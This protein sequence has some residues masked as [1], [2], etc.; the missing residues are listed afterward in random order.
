MQKVTVEANFRVGEEGG[1]G[2][3]GRGRG[4]RG[5]RGGR[6]EGKPMLSAC[7][8]LPAVTP[9]VHQT[10]AV[11]IGLCANLCQDVFACSNLSLLH[12]QG[13]VTLQ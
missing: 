11:T 4:G 8:H 2:G 13:K 12:G 6:F 9:Y 7:Q 10:V 1:F 3:G 5:P